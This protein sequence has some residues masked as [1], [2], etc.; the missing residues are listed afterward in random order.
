MSRKGNG[1][2]SAVMEN[3][4][5]LLKSE[6]L[7]LQSF[8]VI[9]HFQAERIGDLHHCNFRRIKTKIKGLSPAIHR[10]QARLAA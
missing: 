9:D 1:L 4:F 10:Q 2:D 8:E 6:S 5:G 3:S 7:Y